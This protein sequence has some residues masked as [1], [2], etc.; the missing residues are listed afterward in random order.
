MRALGSINFSSKILSGHIGKESIWFRLGEH[1]I[2]FQIRTPK[3]KP[4]FSERTGIKKP[5][6]KVG[7]FRL[8]LLSKYKIEDANK[9]TK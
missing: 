7:D 6:L 8:F 4:L 5:V 9:P 3:Y 2:G 1:G